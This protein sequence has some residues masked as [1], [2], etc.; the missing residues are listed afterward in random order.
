MALH[1]THDLVWSTLLIVT[2]REWSCHLRAT[3]KKL[4]WD[5]CCYMTSHGSTILI[6][7]AHQ[8]LMSHFW[9]I[10][11]ASKIHIFVISI[12][13][14]FKR[15]CYKLQ[16]WNNEWEPPQRM[17]VHCRR[18]NIVA[19]HYTHDLMWSTL[20]VIFPQATPEKV[21]WDICRY[22]TSHGGHFNQHNTSISMSHFWRILVTSNPN[23]LSCQFFFLILKRN[24]INL[25]LE[26]MWENLHLWKKNETQVVC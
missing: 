20:L 5:I 8:V 18:A 13:S 6:N 14:N 11:V 26:T 3:P 25:N 21:A 24:T 10:L 7:M 23:T 15:N 2:P 16:S 17:F 9:R 12:F 19:I 4:A 22:M 1:Y